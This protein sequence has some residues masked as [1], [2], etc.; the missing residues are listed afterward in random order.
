MHKCPYFQNVVFDYAHHPTEIQNAILSAQKIYGEE[1]LVVIFQP[2]T[3]SRTKILL[4]EFLQVFKQNEK[5]IIYKT[6]SAREKEEDGLSAK[7]L[8]LFLKEEG[9]G[10]SYADDFEEL[11]SLLDVL[12]Y[13]SVLLFVGAGDLPQIL[14]QNHF[15][16]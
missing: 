1:K 16:S 10:V 5:T 12:S 3:F 13:D 15:V 7:Q 6:Y 4:D 2:H 11:K 9:K 8:A 14:H